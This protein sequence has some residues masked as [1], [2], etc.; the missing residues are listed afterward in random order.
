MFRVSSRAYDVAAL[1]PFLVQSNSVEA[2]PWLINTT[3]RI[4]DKSYLRS[5]LQ[6]VGSNS[7]TIGLTPLDA[8]VGYRLCQVSSDMR[9]EC[10]LQFDL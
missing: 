5:K 10:R 1:L 9:S 2:S 7:S 8:V 3:E 6:S 4:G